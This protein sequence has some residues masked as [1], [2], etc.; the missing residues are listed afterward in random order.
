MRKKEL[1]RL[2]AEREEKILQLEQRVNTMDALIEGYRDREK[3]L[4]DALTHAHETAAKVVA[5]AEAKA[6]AITDSA[7]AQVDA[8][9]ERAKRQSAQL[10]KQTELTVAE[11]ENTIAAYNAALEKAA[12]EAAANAERFASFSRGKRIASSDLG[13]EVEGLH[14]LPLQEALDLPD[15]SGSPAQLMQNIY[16]IQN[17]IPPEQEEP[18]PSPLDEEV[19]T[20]KDVVVEEQQETYSLDD[21]LE[22][23]IKAG[24][25]HRAEQN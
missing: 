18:D 21:L 20:V 17:R 3:A 19:P 13:A 1:I 14:E 7:Q 12:A 25:Q 22:E 6:Q 8:E 9:L 10:L 2:L 16:K 5:D 15:P 24:E 23:I 4:V 11:Y